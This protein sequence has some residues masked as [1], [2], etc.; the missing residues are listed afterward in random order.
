MKYIAIGGD[1]H[2]D[3]QAVKRSVEVVHELWKFGDI[4]AIFRGGDDGADPRFKEY[5]GLKLKPL[6]KIARDNGF[7]GK[8]R[9]PEVL[10]LFREG[11]KEDEKYSR[12]NVEINQYARE[13]AAAFD[14]MGIPVRYIKGNADGFQDYIRVICASSG[15]KDPDTGG[16]TAHI[17]SMF[18][19][20]GPVF[21]DFGSIFNRPAPYGKGNVNSSRGVELDRINDDIAVITIPYSFDP[22]VDKAMN[23]FCGIPDRPDREC[24]EE[25]L[26]KQLEALAKV[27]PQVIVQVQH[28]PPVQSLVTMLDPRNRALEQAEIYQKAIDA[29]TDMKPAAHL[30]FY[31]HVGNHHFAQAV[32]HELADRGIRTFHWPEEGRGGML[33]LNLDTLE[34]RE[35]KGMIDEVELRDRLWEELKK[36]YKIEEELKEIKKELKQG[37]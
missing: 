15:F 1:A 12:F 22:A 16:Y 26:E 36:K 8:D 13:I 37:T 25:S 4:C 28:E 6:A 33:Y 3:V 27:K 19:S 31:G 29:I 14:D 30:I 23:D 2:S 7:S 18:E 10:R 20:T 17:D 24:I 32:P 35:E 11:L 9:Y 5:D 34:V 21:D